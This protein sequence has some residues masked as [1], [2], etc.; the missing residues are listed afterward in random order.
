VSLAGRL[1][2]PARWA[3]FLPAA[4]VLGIWVAWIPADGGYFQRSWYPAGLFAVGLL[5]AAVAAGA[6]WR[7][8]SRLG[9]AALL[10]LAGFAVWNFASMLWAGSPGSA[11]EA[12][13][14]LLL[15]LVMTALVVLVPWRVGP[16]MLF[17]G[18]WSVAVA[19]ACL[20]VLVGALDTTHFGHYVLV[21][22]WQQPTGYA[23]TAAAI[24]SMAFW[25]A[26]VL[27]T[28][29]RTPAVVQVL[30]LA[31]AAFLLD[32]SFLPESR[33]SL[34]VVL[35]VPIVVAFAPERGRLL[36]RIGVIVIA[37]A[38]AIGPAYDVYSAAHAHRPLAPV[39]HSAAEAMV[40]SVAIAALGALVLVLVE[41]QVKLTPR[42][43]RRARVG[44]VAVLAVVL[45]AGAGVAIADHG[46]ISHYARERWDA[47][48][49]D[50]GVADSRKLRIAQQSSDKRYDYWRVS[51]DMFSAA[52]VGGAGAG[53]FEREYSAHRRH[54]KP[55]RSA[56]SIWMRT[57]GE[58]GAVGLALLA[59]CVCVLLA[60]LV[61]LRRRL[62]AGAR[63]V[64][65][66]CVG[67]S[68][69]F[70][71]HASFDWL[72]LLPA[73]AAPALAL[74][75]LALRLE[76]RGAEAAAVRPFAGRR[77]RLPAAAAGG[78]AVAVALVSLG[79]P[80]LS[81]RYVQSALHRAR[82][83]PAGARRDLDRAASLDPLSPDPRYAAAGIALD[84]GRFG[85]ARRAFE[86]ALDVED[87]W[88]PHFGLALLDS[89][90]RK[91]AEARREIARAG[92]LDAQDPLVIRAAMLIAE[93]KRLDP[94]AVDRKTLA[95]PLY[96]DLRHQ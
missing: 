78:V 41:R 39:V 26:L 23:N 42:T 92:A 55:S 40:P 65:C 64:L 43:L 7:T 14:Q 17:V 66:A 15:Y 28:A 84:H 22:R 69:Y 20:V 36:A 53:N 58:L 52:P 81:S 4:L 75:F 6:R 51:L 46:A 34:V 27:S 57:L 13:D 31:V 89:R 88:Y 93:R 12:A 25:P 85:D 11:W 68:A 2:P 77:A 19:V 3:Q 30:L 76:P 72:E 90:A 86:Q 63:T 29:R 16:A 95:L 94:R 87:G 33:A 49:S 73:L 60:A 91:F 83:D 56:H 62:D 1:A 74:P 38:V 37:A 18:A 71:A 44:A 9:P 32:F 21:D 82:S 59:A 48:K 67:V 10:L 47:F 80:Y 96:K 61:R 70:V 54:A 35:V 5:A 8:G 79:L 24:A 50:S 45:L